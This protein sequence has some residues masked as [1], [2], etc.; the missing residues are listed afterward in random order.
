MTEPKHSIMSWK[1]NKNENAPANHSVYL[2]FLLFG[3]LS[4]VK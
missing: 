2:E 3:V 4:E 1:K